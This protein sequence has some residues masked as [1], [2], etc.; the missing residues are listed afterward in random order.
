MPDRDN[1][2][3]KLRPEDEGPVVLVSVPLAFVTLPMVKLQVIIVLDPGA[4]LLSP[5]K[6]NEA[7]RLGSRTLTDALMRGYARSV[8]LAVVVAVMLPE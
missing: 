3:V 6:V 7:V 8:P 2:V 4:T 5:G 1:L